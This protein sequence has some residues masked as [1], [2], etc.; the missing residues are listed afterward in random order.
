MSGLLDR[1]VADRRQ[2]Q[3]LSIDKYKMQRLQEDCM[4]MPPVRSLALALERRPA[5]IAE[6]KRCSPSSGEFDGYRDPG[7]L[8]EAYQRSGAAAISVLTNEAF[9][10]MQKHDLTRAAE[11]VGI[12]VMRKEFVIS[13][14]DVLETRLLGADAMLLIMRL[15]NDAEAA[16][17]FGIAEQI[18]L[19]VLVEVHD[20]DELER[21]LRLEPKILGVNARNL[22]SLQ[23]DLEAGLA[24]AAQVPAGIRVVAES[25]IRSGADMQQFINRG[26]SSFLVGTEL[27]RHE[28]PERRLTELLQREVANEPR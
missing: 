2:R 1:I 3:P 11:A 21:A 9:F 14:F 12:P 28:Q 13:E 18:G 22:D 16:M 17:L 27:L 24:L 19:E 26:I 20:E 15:L 8:A 6:I 10:G 4:A 7:S 5:V 25:G 23:T